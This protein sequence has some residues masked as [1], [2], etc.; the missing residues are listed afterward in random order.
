MTNLLAEA[1]LLPLHPHASHLEVQVTD[2]VSL[3]CGRIWV[4]MAVVARA[5]KNIFLDQEQPC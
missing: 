3:V 4:R 5:H 2:A 1:Y